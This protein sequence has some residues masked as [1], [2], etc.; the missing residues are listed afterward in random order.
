M[1]NSQWFFYWFH[2]L[3]TK[4]GKT[5]PEND[6]HISWIYNTSALSKKEADYLR[7]K[8]N[9][10]IINRISNWGFSKSIM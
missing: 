2:Q 9:S 3:C 6:N 1:N 7:T 4:Y 5:F 10:F 8:F